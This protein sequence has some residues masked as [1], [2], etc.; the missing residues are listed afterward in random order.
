MKKILCILVPLF[1]FN[2]PFTVYAKTEY[3]NQLNDL[4][5]EYGIDY[6]NIKD[7]TVEKFICQIKSDILEEIHKPFD[8]FLKM[9]GIIILCAVLKTINNDSNNI[10]DTLCTL[11]VFISILTPLETLI[12]SIGENIFA[13]KNFMISFLPILS[14]I[15]MASGEFVTSTIYNGLFFTS[16]IF[17]ADFCIKTILPSINLF[18]AMIVSNALSPFIRLKSL[19]EFYLKVVRW[20]MRAAVSLICFALTF[21]TTISQGK[22]TLAIK[23]GKLFAGSAIPIIGSSLQEAEG[24]VFAGMEVIKGFAGATG[25]I[26]ILYIF[27]PSIISL[28]VY[29]VYTNCLFIICDMFDVKSISECVK[30][31]VNIIELLISIVLLFMVM[32]IFSLTMMIAFTNGV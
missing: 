28:V 26:V 31:F 27:L 13:I 11:I 1:I 32:L 25:M 8:M 6:E 30:G 17:I 24:S 22:D 23:T 5:D 9:S 29:W 2:L 12:T 16:L 21:Q 18:F 19:S 3:E 15:S 14:G 4:T 20:S 7:I 10:L